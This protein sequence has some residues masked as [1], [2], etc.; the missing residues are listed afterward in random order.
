MR[1]PRLSSE[2]ALVARGS[3]EGALLEGK[4]LRSALAYRVEVGRGRG[5]LM[6]GAEKAGKWI[7]VVSNQT[8][9]TW[10]PKFEES[11]LGELD[12]SNPFSKLRSSTVA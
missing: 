9:W 12:L 10:A 11:L 5:R 2:P 1:S 8:A 4:Q 7:A 6:L 3:F